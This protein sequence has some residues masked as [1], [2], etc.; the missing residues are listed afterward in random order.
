M[1]DK[2][3]ETEVQHLKRAVEELAFLNEL[4]LAIGSSFNSEEI[5][6]TLIRKSISQIKAEQGAICLV[7]DEADKEMKTLVRTMVS[8][9]S[10]KPFRLDD[11]FLGWMQ[12][13]KKSLNITDPHN[14][15]RFK[16]VKWDESVRSVACVPLIVKS[17]LTGI[18]SMFNKIKSKSFTDDDLRLLSIIAGQSAQIVET[19]RL[20][21][22][23]QA[24][25]LLQEEGR[26]AR[27]I[28]IK[29]LPKSD[30]DIPEYDIAGTS[31]PAMSV[32][33]DYYDFIPI[34]DN[35]IAI[36][37]GDISGKGIPAALLM[38]NLQATVRAQSLSGNSPRECVNRSN[39]LL[40]RSTDTDKFATLFYAI[41]D[42][43]NNAFCYSNAGH[44]PPVFIKKDKSPVLLIPNRPI[45][46]FLDNIEYCD[47][48]TSIEPG[49]L[50]VIYS[51][52]VTEAVDEFE[53]EFGEDK[54]IKLLNEYKGLSAK[55]IIR[56]VLQAVDE[57]SKNVQQTDDITLVVIKR[58]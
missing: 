1:K 21:E 53:N 45:L 57:H 35:R 46:G 52:G 34:N 50:F 5:M 43:E 7:E 33:G 56:I 28:Q 3:I 14:D 47:E 42:M 20:Y 39:V 48:T 36:C 27:E 40:Y 13:N 55:E 15:D 4:T 22:E 38:A 37:L 26:L 30:P 41:L 16:G 31:R 32:G 2:S 58:K 24:L 8:H 18:L 29:L 23:E 25:Y 19:A 44:N 6:Q 11:C 12:I 10:G 9:G 51:D 17:K 49:D 54:F